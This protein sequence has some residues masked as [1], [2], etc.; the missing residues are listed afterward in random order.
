[1]AAKE[2]QNIGWINMIQGHL[3]KKWAIAQHFYLKDFPC[4]Q[5]LPKGTYEIWKKSFLPSLIK[6]GLDLWELRKGK[7]HGTNPQE[8]AQIRRK[9]LNKEIIKK[10]HMGSKS[11][12][13]A[14]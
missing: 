7:V 4:L 10:F 3:S 9:R 13:P 1:M 14:Q 2:Q 12:S 6:F 5:H 8:T 11:V